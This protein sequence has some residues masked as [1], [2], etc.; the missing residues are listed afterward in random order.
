MLLYILNDLM[1]YY[2]NVKSTPLYGYQA[3]GMDSDTIYI[4]YLF[5]VTLTFNI[6]H[7]QFLSLFK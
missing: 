7:M 2:C 4:V 1:M 6:H 3:T 5:K